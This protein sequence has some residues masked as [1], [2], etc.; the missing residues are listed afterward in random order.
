MEAIADPGAVINALQER[1]TQL[2]GELRVQEIAADNDQS[3]RLHDGL[4]RLRLHGVIPLYVGNLSRDE[5]RREIGSSSPELG[6][7]FQELWWL[8]AAPVPD[9]VRESISAAARNGMS[10]WY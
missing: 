10:R 1:I 9:D 7:A 4:R 6:D 5:L 3:K 8:D 2:Q